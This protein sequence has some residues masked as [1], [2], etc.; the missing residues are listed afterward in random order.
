MAADDVTTGAPPDRTPAGHSRANGPFYQTPDSETLQA[1]LTELRS[2]N[3]RL[4]RAETAGHA[5]GKL[6][7]DHVAPFFAKLAANPK[8]RKLIGS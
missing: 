3:E 2:I 6:F 8:I 4:D 7:A 1:I 5:A